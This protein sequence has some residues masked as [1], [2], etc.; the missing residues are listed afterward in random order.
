MRYLAYSKPS[1]NVSFNYDDYFVD[2]AKA[3]C[4]HSPEEKNGFGFIWDNRMDRNDI[5]PVGINEAEFISRLEKESNENERELNE[6]QWKFSTQTAR[7]DALTAAIP[8]KE[9]IKL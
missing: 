9:R 3:I 7:L 5:T 8:L 6:N 4:E 1:L 2:V